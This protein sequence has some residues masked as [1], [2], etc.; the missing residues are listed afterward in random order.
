MVNLLGTQSC[1][2]FL[3]LYFM[4]P[5]A[6]TILVHQGRSYEISSGQVQD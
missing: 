1:M 4:P 6:L 5:Y 2:K 3:L